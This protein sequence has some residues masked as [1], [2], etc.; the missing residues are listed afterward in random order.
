MRE[1]LEYND[2]GILIRYGEEKVSNTLEFKAVGLDDYDVIYRYTSKYGQHSCQ[3]SFTSMYSLWEKYGDEY[4]EA[5]GFLLVHRDGLDTPELA[6]YLAPLGEG[7]Y[8]K[9]IEALRADAHSRGKKLCFFTLTRESKEKLES[10]FPGEFSCELR[11][12]YA[13]Y[14]Y[15]TDKMQSLPGGKLKHR[16]QE[17][18]WFYDSYGD[19]IEELPITRDLFD[20]I[21]KCEMRWLSQ[22]LETHDREGLMR[23]FRAIGV[24]LEQFEELRMEGFVIKIDGEIQGFFYGTKL[25]DECFDAIVCKGNRDYPNIYRAL[26]ADMVKMGVGEYKYVNLEEDLG[27][28]GL[29]SMKRSYCP[30]ILINKYVVTEL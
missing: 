26:F 22:C 12:D 18:K 11:E 27:I 15:L 9:A 6:F 7:N 5:D 24:E 8:K 2:L 20:E 29:R 21:Y 10:C 28:E 23:E 1:V 30:D 16:R 25:S 4:C 13:E 3:H 14:V 19:R 17:L